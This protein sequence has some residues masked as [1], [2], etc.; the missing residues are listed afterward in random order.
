VIRTPVFD[1]L[2]KEGMLFTHSFSPNPSCSP[3]RALLLSVG[4]IVKELAALVSA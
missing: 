1:R 3:S 4:S 2:A